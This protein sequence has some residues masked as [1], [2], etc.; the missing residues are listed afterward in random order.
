MAPVLIWLVS[1]LFLH[2]L[3]H[4]FNKLSQ[5]PEPDAK[6]QSYRKRWAKSSM[7]DTDDKWESKNMGSDI[8]QA[9]VQVPAPPLTSRVPWSKLL[10]L[11]EPQTS[12]DE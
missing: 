6:Q 11:S 9:R 2:S 5:A 7:E 10:S 1:S 4:S 12:Q 3:I 8:R